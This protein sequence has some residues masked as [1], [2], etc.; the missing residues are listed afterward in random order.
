M[1]SPTRVSSVGIRRHNTQINHG[2]RGRDDGVLSGA[3][4]PIKKPDSFRVAGFGVLVRNGGNHP[5]HGVCLRCEF[6]GSGGNGLDPTAKRYWVKFMSAGVY[7][8][9]REWLMNR[10]GETSADI[11]VLV[12]RLQDATAAALTAVDMPHNVDAAN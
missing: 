5:Q 7:G 8:I 4:L 11:H 9:W 12:G 10:Q 2:L 1:H 6:E 3:V